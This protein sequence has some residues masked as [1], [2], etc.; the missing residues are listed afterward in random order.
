MER[1]L[2]YFVPENYKL[3][4]VI[5]KFKKTIGGMVVIKGV[6]KAETVKFHVVSLKIKSVLVD[7][8]KTDFLCE[9]DVLKITNVV[10]GKHEIK[11][12]YDGK[13]NE[14]MQGAYLSTYEHNGKMEIIV[15]TQF[16]SHYAREAFPC[17]DEPAAKAVFE[18]SLT[19]PEKSEDLVIAN[20]SIKT[21]VKNTTVFEPTPRMSTYLLAW[22]IGRFHG[23]SVTNA[24]GTKITTYAALNQELDT[25]DFANDIAAKSLEFYDYNFG[26]SYPLEKL[27]QVALPDFEA[28]AMENWGLV[29]YRESMLLAGKTATLDTKKGVALTVAHELSHQWFGDLVTMQ[30]WN[31]LWLNESFASVMEYYAVDFIHPEY[32]IFENF[33]MGDALVALKRDAYSGV[34]SVHQDV[35]NP[36]EIATLFDPAIV[37]A[38]GA[39]LMLMLIRA[40]GWKNFC[41]GITDYF[42]KY[43]YENTVGDDLWKS[44]K[45]YADFDPHKMMHSFIDQ[46]GYP[47]I[48]N[49]SGKFLQKRFLLDGEMIES[50]WPLPEINEDMSGHYILNLSEKEF[51]ERLKKF[52]S[53]S[54]EE[55]LRLLID[56]SL[57]AKTDLASSASL[58][59]L[60]D[61]FKNESSAAV[62]G[63]ILTIVN[64]LKIFFKFGSEEEKKFKKFVG[65]LVAPKLR[66]IGIKTRKNDDE[67]A[68][69]LR[70]TLLALDYYAETKENLIKLAEL[71]EDDFSKLDAEIRMDIL[72]AKIYVE[73]EVYD[74]YLEAYQ[75]LADPELKSDL[76][77]AMT[78]S[79]NKENVKK[80][81]KLLEKPEIVKPQDQFYLFMYLYRNPVARE[82]VFLWLTEHWNYVAKMVGDKSLDNY[83]RYIATT[84]KTEKEFENYCEFFKPMKK[85]PA[86]LRAIKVGENEIRAQ[87]KLIKLD[88]ASVYKE[89]DSCL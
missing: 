57:V 17:I 1:F 13:L 34:Q 54:L 75:K 8:K 59:P 40:M 12:E 49:D 25:V 78:L 24:H 61:K 30:W 67:N 46:P 80:S 56:R 73:P 82:K 11:I 6:A 38:K 48:M 53:L 66:E 71:Y 37:Y 74:E 4:L 20:T 51:N 45:P 10:L 39:R 70:S 87:L 52:E 76:I 9:D 18:L 42:E 64:S 62:W 68:V 83:P 79:R 22:V 31:D 27:D 58:L 36:E 7:D 81:M 41:K 69:R 21:V 72:D 29:T 65:K 19:L 60:V 85:N 44:L 26:V 32:K 86:L 43:K 28:G 14:N 5:D 2:D 33:F 77:L 55:K 63:I 50:D 23:R 35:E 88:K 3:D 89:L 15:A 84:I 47:V 16:E